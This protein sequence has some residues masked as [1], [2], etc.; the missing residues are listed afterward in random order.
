MSEAQWDACPW[1][2]QRAYCEGLLAEGL[3]E[4]QPAPAEMPE[5]TVRTADTGGGVIDLA[6]MRDQLAA[7]G[8]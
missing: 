7:S 5:V 2:R 6:A 8:H 3:I 1:D 4:I